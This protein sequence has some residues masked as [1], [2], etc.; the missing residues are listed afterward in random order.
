MHRIT[1]SVGFCV[2][3]LTSSAVAQDSGW[4]AFERNDVAAASTW[5]DQALAQDAANQRA[6][7]LRIL[8]SFLSGQFEEALSD[9]EQLAADYSGRNESLVRLVLDAYLHL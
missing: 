1:S 2:L 4:Q 3:A 8:T 6:H 9:Y 5:A 7:H